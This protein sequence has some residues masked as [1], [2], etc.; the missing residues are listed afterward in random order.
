MKQ[1][2]IVHRLLQ[3]DE[4]NVQEE[5]DSVPKGQGDNEGSE[6]DVVM[7]DAST[8]GHGEAQASGGGGGTSEKGGVAGGQG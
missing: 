3:G 6:G 8:K 4:F 5:L 1:G 2:E 7:E